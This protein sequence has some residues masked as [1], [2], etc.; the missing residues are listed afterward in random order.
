MKKRP[1]RWI[2]LFPIVGLEAMG[3]IANGRLQLRRVSVQTQTC[4]PVSL[5]RY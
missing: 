1:Q 2:E 3:L 5:T 4:N